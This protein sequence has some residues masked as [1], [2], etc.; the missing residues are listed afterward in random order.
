MKE[1]NYSN[2]TL[3]YRTIQFEHVASVVQRPYNSIL[4]IA[5]LKIPE[6]N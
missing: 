1:G 5:A 2:P 3:S 6:C 4:G